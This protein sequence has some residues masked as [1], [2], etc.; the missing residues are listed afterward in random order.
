MS[1]L[2]FSRLGCPTSGGF[3]F[4]RSAKLSALSY[5]RL[6]SNAVGKAMRKS[7]HPVCKIGPSAS[8]AGG[9]YSPAMV[10]IAVGEEGLNDQDRCWAFREPSGCG[11]RGRALG[12]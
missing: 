4:A 7:A 10:A 3:D 9:V 8:G 5:C 2:Q 1:F 11:P 12:L 6:I